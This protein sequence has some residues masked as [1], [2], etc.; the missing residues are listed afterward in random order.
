M[1]LVDDA[2]DIE[3]SRGQSRDPAEITEKQEWR[4]PNQQI[5]LDA[6]IQPQNEKRG[7]VNHETF[8]PFPRLH[9]ID[10]SVPPKHFLLLIAE[11]P[12][13]HSSLSFQLR[14]GHA[15]LNKHLHR[16]AKVPRNAISERKPCITFS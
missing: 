11:L 2:M 5:C 9:E 14:S 12:R 8:S 13:C 3:S 15:L 6:T 1:V 16:I 4:S 7:N 10:R